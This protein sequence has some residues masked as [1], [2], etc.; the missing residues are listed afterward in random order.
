MI[1]ISNDTRACIGGDYETQ[2]ASVRRCPQCGRAMRSGRQ[3]RVLGWVLAVI[4]AFLLVFVGAIAVWMT[5]VIRHADEPG[6][7]V[8]FTGGTDMLLLI[9]GLFALVLSFGVVSVASGVWQ[10]H[11]GRPNRKLMFIGL[12]FGIF[13]YV[14][15]RFA[16]AFLHGSH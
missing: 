6:A 9:Y 8:G 4:G 1:P 11:Y 12:G 2:D 13:F 15:S 16:H 7:K 14:A 5:N 3:V 10:I